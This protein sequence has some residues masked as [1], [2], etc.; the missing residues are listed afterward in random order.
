MNK[1]PLEAVLNLFNRFSLQQKILI[2]GSVAITIILLAILL[3][4]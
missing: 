4:F 3:F 2:A 1:N